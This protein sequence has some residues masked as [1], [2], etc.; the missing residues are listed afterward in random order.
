MHPLYDAL[1]MPCV[2]VRVTRGALVAQPYTYAPSCCRTSQHR[3]T[4]ILISV[5]L[6]NELADPVFNDVRLGYSR[7]GPM[8]FYRPKLLYPFLSSTIFPFPFFLS[9][10]CYCGAEIFGLI[11]C[12][13][14]SP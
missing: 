14:L 13:L 3:K 12:R 6:W 7:A 5:S 9:I 8:F 1:P 11:G 4:F 10:D 2:L